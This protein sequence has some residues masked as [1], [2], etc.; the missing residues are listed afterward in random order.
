MRRGFLEY[1]D[2]NSAWVLAEPRA[3]NHFLDVSRKN[4]TGEYSVGKN[5]PTVSYKGMHVLS[6]MGSEAIYD[7]EEKT[8]IMIAGNHPSYVQRSLYLD[9]IHECNSVIPLE[10]L[11]S[12]DGYPDYYEVLRTWDEVKE[13]GNGKQYTISHKEI[14]VKI[15][16]KRKCVKWPQGVRYGNGW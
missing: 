7:P 15:D 9:A 10:T 12:V 6:E 3:G 8:L 11:E 1:N 4:F 16:G 14:L 13:G 2:Q 5:C